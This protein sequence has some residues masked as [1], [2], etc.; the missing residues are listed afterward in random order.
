VE[1]Q[2]FAAAHSS[3]ISIPEHLPLLSLLLLQ[4][5]RQVFEA[6]KGKLKVVGRAGVGVDNVDLAAATEVR[7]CGTHTIRQSFLYMCLRVFLQEGLT[8]EQVHLQLRAWASNQQRHTGIPI[9][10]ASCT[11]GSTAVTLEYAQHTLQEL[12]CGNAWLVLFTSVIELCI[13]IDSV[14]LD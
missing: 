6:A 13:Y 5:T 3:S 8:T 7:R 12:F 14:Y 2:Q 11:E 10:P 1:H 4:V 9:R